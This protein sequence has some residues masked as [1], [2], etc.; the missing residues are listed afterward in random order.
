MATVKD[1]RKGWPIIVRVGTCNAETDGTTAIVKKYKQLV[2]FSFGKCKCLHTGHGSLGVIY[3]MGDT[4]L[5]TSTTTKEKD[6]GVT[7][8]ANMKVS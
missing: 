2:G 3:E 8:N 7:I 4:V 5:C 1:P 6:L